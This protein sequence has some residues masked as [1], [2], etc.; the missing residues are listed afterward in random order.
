[1]GPFKNSTVFG[2]MNWM[3]T[4][5]AMK[6]LQEMVKLVSFLKSDQFNK[7]DLEAFDISAETTK[8]DEFIEGMGGSK[9]LGLDDGWQEVSVDIQ[10][11]DG[12]KHTS[13]DDIPVF[14]V[15][16]RHFRNLT[17][18]VKAALHDR[19]SRF[20]HHTPFKLFW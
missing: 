8:F 20:F 1:F 19:A 9:P 14:P 5:S 6:S 18:V 13:Y 17:E 11:P 12:K 4:G 15:P 7:S 10:V 2:L 3:W 16:G